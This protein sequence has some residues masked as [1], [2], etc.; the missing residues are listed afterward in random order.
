[1]ARGRTSGK[2]KKMVTRYPDRH[3]SISKKPWGALVIGAGIICVVIVI[4]FL[5]GIG[6]GLFGHGSGTPAAQS[7]TT[8]ATGQVTQSSQVTGTNASAATFTLPTPVP[9]PGTGVYVRVGYLGGYTGSYS[10]NGASQ[11]VK[12]SGYRLYTINQTV[13][14]ITAAFVKADDTAKR[15]LSVE[16]WKDGR[17]LASNATSA[18]FGTASVTANV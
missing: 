3:S 2:V 7:G 12:S 8:P 1:M 5:T 17:E 13:G 9:V 6:S 4:L 18:P 11:A 14:T 10:V 16:I 15:N